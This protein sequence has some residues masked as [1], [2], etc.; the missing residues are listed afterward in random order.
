[1]WLVKCCGNTEEW[2]KQRWNARTR[3]GPH[4]LSYLRTKVCGLI[5]GI[6]ILLHMHEFV[7]ASMCKFRGRNYIKGGK[8]VNREN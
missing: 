1:M 6:R 3:C 4:I 2:R 7:C 5:F 8:N